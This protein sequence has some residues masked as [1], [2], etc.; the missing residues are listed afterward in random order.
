MKYA[1]GC[2]EFNNYELKYV[3]LSLSTFNLNICLVHISLLWQFAENFNT[4]LLSDLC[5]AW[6]ALNGQIRPC[7][8]LFFFSNASQI[9][10]MGFWSGGASPSSSVFQQTGDLHATSALE[11]NEE[12]VFLNE[13][14]S[15]AS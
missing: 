6:K 5:Q 7:F 10:W 14:L 9:C 15:P 1:D 2:S 8:F 12:K 13:F 11:K 3:P 4:N